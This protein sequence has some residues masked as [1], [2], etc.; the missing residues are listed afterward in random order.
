METGE[1]KTF[2]AFYQVSGPQP[3]ADV[4]LIAVSMMKKG[5]I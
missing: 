4:H 3:N 2:K 1:P 5:G